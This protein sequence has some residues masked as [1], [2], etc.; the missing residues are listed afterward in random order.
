[1]L[2]EIFFVFS[3]A[4][5]KPRMLLSGFT[6]AYKLATCLP[7]VTL[8]RAFCLAKSHQSKHGVTDAAALQP[9][10]PVTLRRREGRCIRTRGQENADCEKL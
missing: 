1:M 8:W 10:E 3:A 7:R 6:Y 2:A 9:T 4:C 5:L